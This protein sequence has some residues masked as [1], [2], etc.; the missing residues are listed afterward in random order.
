VP[1]ECGTVEDA[2]T[3]RAKL[4]RDCANYLG[5]TQPGINAPDLSAG[6]GG[7]TVARARRGPTGT[8]G[9]ADVGQTGPV[10]GIGTDLGASGGR[11]GN[12]PT[13]PK[14]GDLLPGASKLGGEPSLPPVHVP[15]P[16]LPRGASGPTGAGAVGSG[17]SG[18]PGHLLDYLMGP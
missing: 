18:I 6:A 2:K 1:S 4:I 8:G 16:A 10:S 7:P 14:L 11:Q 17:N 9:G 5:P 13:L 12:G 3:V 15:I